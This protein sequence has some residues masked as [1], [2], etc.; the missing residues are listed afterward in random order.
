LKL[1]LFI[2][3][4]V[5]PLSF[6]PIFAEE[7]IE[8][9]IFPEKIQKG[10]DIFVEIYV[11][12]NNNIV[13]SELPEIE[14]E[15]LDS[16]ITKIISII[17]DQPFKKKIK[18][19]AVNE[20]ETSIYVNIQGLESIEIPIK[21]YGNLSIPKKIQLDAFPSKM[22]INENKE[23]ILFLTLTDQSGIP[24]KAD[25]DY[26]VKIGVSK[27]NIISLSQSDV[28]IPKGESN[29]ILPF[30]AKAE[31]EITITSQT[32]ELRDSADIIINK[33][34]EESIEV[35]LVPEEINSFKTASGNIVAHY[36]KD[37]KLSNAP[38]DII[39]HY[40]ITNDDEISNS[41][42][43]VDELNSRGY[44]QINNGESWG[45]TKFSIQ[46]QGVTDEYDMTI[47]SQNPLTVIETTFETID[48]ELFDDKE[49]Q[50]S[51][52]PIIANGEKQLVGIIYL[53]DE[54]GHPVIANREIVV[55]F[56]TSDES[57]SVENAVIKN[58]DH[59]ALVFGRVET[60]SSGDISITPKTENPTLVDLN[61]FG[62]QKD[63]TFLN[64]FVPTTTIT[65]NDEVWGIL[66]LE[67]IDERLL[68]FPQEELTITDEHNFEV[69]SDKIIPHPYFS[70]VPIRTINSVL[71]HWQ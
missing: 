35:S 7:T 61:I 52:F 70:L 23:G 17:N 31:G 36:Y 22:N 3:I 46:E 39:I 10:E 25:K 58:G 12:N 13:L 50:F 48:V 37:G 49:I 5:I 65:E 56:G 33:G 18:L 54:N 9:Q 20:G 15:S 21:V 62:E 66:Y 28:I 42:S 19:E 41:S 40:K 24:I 67:S 14:A 11:E 43:E 60:Y 47:T 45:H 57:A 4:S 64:F 8:Y 63:E 27:R 59:S 32:D 29:V 30:L 71:F 68:S 6:L 2:L 16:S 51:P 34:I 1:L 69:D 55:S 38:R 26:L 53:E 44:F